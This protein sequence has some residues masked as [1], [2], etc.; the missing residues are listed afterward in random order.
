MST[1]S[2]LLMK[3]Q[4]PSLASTRKHPCS[5][6]RPLPLLPTAVPPPPMRPAPLLALW[7]VLLPT[8][9][10]PPMASERTTRVVSGVHM[11]P[12]GRAAR[13]PIARLMARPG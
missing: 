11:M 3:S 8:L 12:A 2:L 4:T 1:T 9:L 5:E 13:S 10:M 7:H 6:T